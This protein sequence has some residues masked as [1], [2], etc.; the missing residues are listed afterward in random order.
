VF[1]A[2][3]NLTNS[4]FYFLLDIDFFHYYYHYCNY[5]IYIYRI[6]CRVGTAAAV[7]IY[8]RCTF[9]YTTKY[10]RGLGGIGFRPQQEIYNH[11]VVEII[12]CGR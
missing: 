7:V 4:R 5:I 3:R 10:I 1:S 2:A 9:T 8:Y 6:L 12:L 11:L